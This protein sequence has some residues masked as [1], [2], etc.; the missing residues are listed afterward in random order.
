MLWF[1]LDVWMLLWSISW[2]DH[3]DLGFAASPVYQSFCH[4]SSQTVDTFWQSSPRSPSCFLVQ[5]RILVLSGQSHS[6]NN[7]PNIQMKPKSISF[8]A[9]Y[10][11]L[12]CFDGSRYHTN[13]IH[14]KLSCQ[15]VFEPL[16]VSACGASFSPIFE[17]HSSL[18]SLHFSWFPFPI[19]GPQN[20]TEN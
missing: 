11:Y 20:K 8:E 2:P 6:I 3:T 4:F 18:I 7:D 19:C 15:I 12:F 16:Q 5:F 17:T 9:R 10:P 13:L 14:S 1:W